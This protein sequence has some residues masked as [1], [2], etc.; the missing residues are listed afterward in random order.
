MDFTGASW[1]FDQRCRRRYPEFL[2]Y[3]AAVS[4]SRH[5]HTDGGISVIPNIGP[6][7]I[8]IV[9]VIALVIFGPKKLPELGSSMGRSIR[10]FG[11]GLKGDDD[12]PA[13]A[14]ASERPREVPAAGES[15][16]AV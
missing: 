5:F 15:K 4:A 14:E 2:T 16:T 10:G 8:A 1:G 3:P 11:K 13:I 9:V 6:L 7:E 12:E